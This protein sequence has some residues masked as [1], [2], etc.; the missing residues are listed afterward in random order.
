VF[1]AVDDST[2]RTLRSI[3]GGLSSAISRLSCVEGRKMEGGRQAASLSD[4]LTLK[5]WGGAMVVLLPF[6]PRK[7]SSV[8]DVERNPRFSWTTARR[9]MS[10]P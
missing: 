8:V 3:H 9:S 5:V 6:Y 2:D 4:W 1:R 7:S 10:G